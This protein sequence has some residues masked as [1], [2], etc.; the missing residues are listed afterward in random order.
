MTIAREVITMSKNMTNKIPSKEVKYFFVLNTWDD[1]TKEEIRKAL[2][3][4]QWVHLGSSCIG[5]TRAEM[6][7]QAGGEWLHSEF[8]NIKQG[9]DDCG[10]KCYRL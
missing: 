6:V 4:N 3:E 10:W 2:N 8:P 5:H 9:V 1:N 7:E